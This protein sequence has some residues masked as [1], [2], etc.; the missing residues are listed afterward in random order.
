[1][2]SLYMGSL[3]FINF[4]IFDHLF[5]LSRVTSY[6]FCV[7]RLS[8]FLLTY[9]LFKWHYH[10][11]NF[12]RAMTCPRRVNFLTTMLNRLPAK[13]RLWPR[14]ARGLNVIFCPFCDCISSAFYSCL[15][16]FLLSFKLFFHCS[17]TP[18]SMSVLT[19]GV[20]TRLS[21]ACPPL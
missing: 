15:A 14:N 6:Y 3:S 12:F 4:Y 1:M 16:C 17:S 21:G 11:L 5:R 7:A 20:S 10:S 13:T 9:L 18:F 8:L 19:F 2:C